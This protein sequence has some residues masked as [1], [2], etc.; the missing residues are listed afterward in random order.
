MPPAAARP[1]ESRSERPYI[2]AGL[3]CPVSGGPAVSHEIPIQ[4]TA[5]L[6]TKILDFRGFDSS[7]I[8]DSGVEF[9]C[10]SDNFPDFFEPTNLGSDNLSREIG[11]PTP[12]GVIRV[13]PARDRFALESLAPIDHRTQQAIPDDPSIFKYS[14]L[15]TENQYKLYGQFSSFQFAKLQ[16]EGFNSHIQMQVIMC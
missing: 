7:G 13:Q 9:S 10:P 4:T 5:N 3:G 8:L 11:R 12:G 2:F 16:I 15:T 14:G 6:R 1:P